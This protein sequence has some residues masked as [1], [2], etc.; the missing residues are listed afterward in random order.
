MGLWASLLP[1]LER[2][3]LVRRPPKSCLLQAIAAPRRFP[4]PHRPPTA[5]GIMRVTRYHTCDWVPKGN[6]LASVEHSWNIRGTFVE[7]SWNIR[8]TI[9]RGS[10]ARVASANASPC[11][12]YAL[13]MPCPCLAYA[14][15][16]PCLCHAYAMPMPCLCHA[17][18]C[19]QVDQYVNHTYCYCLLCGR[20]GR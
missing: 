2:T 18:G 19:K 14:L 12:A 3:V 10:M 4:S 20:L 8:G 16:M 5:L 9:A 17:Y 13:P 11:L 6:A 15:P 7:H 1:A